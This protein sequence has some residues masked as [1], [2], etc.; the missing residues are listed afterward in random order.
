MKRYR[1]LHKPHILINLV[2]VSILAI[3]IFPF[4]WM[5]FGAFKTNTEVMTMPPKLFPDR[6]N[7]DNFT[8]ISKLFP[9]GRVLFNSVFVAVLTTGA[10]VLFCAM[11]GYVFA[12]ISF[13]GRELLF[14]LILV[15]MMI[16]FQL[17]MITLYKI[18]VRLKMNNSYLGLILPGTYNALGIFMLRQNIKTIP[19][20]Y[21]EASF[22]DGATHTGAF[23]KII[24][25]LCKPVMATVAILGFMSSWNSFIW[26]LIIISD[27]N[28]LTL[29]V[30]L[31]RIQGRWT[32]QWNLMMA[33]NLISFIPMLLVYI[34]AQK[35][36][37]KSVAGSGIKG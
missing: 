29:P 15:T 6:F 33:G 31:S 8:Q 16:P 7:L 24:L 32:T 19:D 25:P 34:F 13:R 36:F 17:S 4:I 9:L 30:G 23:F 5:L 28:M 18:F 11:A 14:I 35:Y 22:M 12:K 1:R 10:Q 2:M 21:L 20:S 37:I 27:S 3:V 26:P